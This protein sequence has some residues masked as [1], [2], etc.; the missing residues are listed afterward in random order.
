LCDVLQAPDLA[1]T[2]VSIGRIVQVGYS[3]E[4]DQDK[5][6]IRK[7]NGST[8]GNIL[9]GSNG[10]FKLDHSFA[11]ITPDKS[12]DI[13][14]LH[15]KLGHISLDAIRAL[16]R[17]N[18]NAITGINLI[19]NSISSLCNTCEHAKMTRKAIHKERE[20]PPAQTFGEEI[21]IDV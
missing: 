14:A 7:R 20:A 1:L 17:S 11:A 18:A 10:L 8:I 12:V 2:V 3:V 9:A 4:F 21:H 16:V 15:R 6:V 5:C 19:G 13:H